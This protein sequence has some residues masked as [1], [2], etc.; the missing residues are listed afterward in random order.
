MYES[1]S[2]IAVRVVTPGTIYSKKD[3]VVQKAAEI[4]LKER[5]AVRAIS[6]WVRTEEGETPL[7]ALI[8]KQ[9]DSNGDEYLTYHP[10]SD[11]FSRSYWSSALKSSF[12]DKELKTPF[13]LGQLSPPS[14]E[15]S[16]KPIC[17]HLVWS[18]ARLDALANIQSYN[19]PIEQDKTKQPAVIEFNEL[20][21]IASNYATE[22]NTRAHAPAPP[23]SSSS[24]PPP[25]TRLLHPQSKKRASPSSS[26]P[27]SAKK[28]K[29]APT[30][31][32]TEYI[33]LGCSEFRPPILDTIK[34]SSMDAIK[35]IYERT[36]S[37]LGDEAL[38]QMAA[39]K[40]D[41]MGRVCIAWLVCRNNIPI[42]SRRVSVFRD[43]YLS[44]LYQYAH[45][46]RSGAALPE[47]PSH[48]IDENIHASIVC[49][50]RRLFA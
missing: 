19:F 34:M 39:T 47:K 38:K 30:S 26:S 46:I 3:G 6:S 29:A 35:V 9:N 25:I 7:E 50:Y 8:V 49:S 10:P 23:S 43:E 41:F 20:F 32:Q 18:S 11:A 37:R 2:R 24:S 48:K 31:L 44:A 15:N 13:T 28:R 21:H 14:R 45:H 5:N 1:L 22:Y 12:P 4:E 16:E 36:L 27:S 17:G 40:W 42:A 33:I